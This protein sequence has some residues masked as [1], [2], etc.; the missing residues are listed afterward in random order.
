MNLYL[1]QRSRDP[2]MFM[3]ATNTFIEQANVFNQN[4]INSNINI[5]SSNV[6][7]IFQ[8]IK[9]FQFECLINEIDKLSNEISPSPSPSPSPSSSSLKM[10]HLRNKVDH[11]NDINMLKKMIKDLGDQWNVKLNV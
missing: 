2:T 8:N 5:N 4:I 6:S 3:K 1:D 10:E 11:I 9:N 7:V